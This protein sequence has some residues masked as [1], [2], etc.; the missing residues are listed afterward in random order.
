MPFDALINDLTLSDAAHRLGLV[1]VPRAVLKTH[2]QN[3]LRKHP[4]SWWYYHTDLAAAMLFAGFFISL[5]TALTCLVVGISALLSGD[6]NASL[7]IALIGAAATYVF[8]RINT[9]GALTGRGPV[10]CGPAYWREYNGSSMAMYLKAPAEM[11]DYA[12]QL[13]RMVPGAEVVVGE[14]LQNQVSLDP[15]LLVRNCGSY[16]FPNHG[17]DEVVLAIW[18]K[19]GV[20]HQA[21]IRE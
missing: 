14:L 19:S 17:G 2:K 1:P 5:F 4:A 7:I 13:C 21:T 16:V 6:A 8:R 11:V 3:E 12:E 9:T 20:L 10:I 18:D 15:Y